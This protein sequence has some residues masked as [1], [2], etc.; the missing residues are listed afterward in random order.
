[1]LSQTLL[2]ESVGVCCAQETV[3]SD[4]FTLP[5]NQP[6]SFDVGPEDGKQRS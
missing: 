6:C 3:A 2:S 5:M 4:F 1:M